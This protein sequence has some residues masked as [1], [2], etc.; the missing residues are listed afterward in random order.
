MARSS[1]VLSVFATCWQKKLGPNESV[2]T[3][4]GLLDRVK[5]NEAFFMC[6]RVPYILNIRTI[7]LY[8]KL[9][10]FV[11]FGLMRPS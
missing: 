8:Q 11:L 1:L 6:Y 5:S 9:S 2:P 7:M 10:P 4:P 3:G